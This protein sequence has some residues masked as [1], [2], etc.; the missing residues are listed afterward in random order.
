MPPPPSY[1]HFVWHYDRANGEG[2]HC[3]VREYKWNHLNSYDNPDDQIDH[4]DEIIMN[5]SNNYI[6]NENKTFYRH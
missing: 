6:P 1:K 2:L 4:F 5:I 3:A